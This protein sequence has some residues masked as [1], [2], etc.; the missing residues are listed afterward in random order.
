MSLWFENGKLNGRLWETID[1]PF[2]SVD[3]GTGKRCPPAPMKK[4]RVEIE[5]NADPFDCLPFLRGD[6]TL[7]IFQPRVVRT[8]EQEL[9][10]QTAGV[11]DPD[12][13]QEIILR[14]LTGQAIRIFSAKVGRDATIAEGI[15]MRREIRK[16]LKK[17]N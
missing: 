6:P 2:H 13:R 7:A 10:H 3:P 15:K 1:E 12:E 16:L 14:V 9:Q 11:T 4:R 8:P 17:Q 5:N